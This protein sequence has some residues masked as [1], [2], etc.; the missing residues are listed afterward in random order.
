MC[1]A[2]FKIPWPGTALILVLG[3]WNFVL[4]P[5]F[6]VPKIRFENVISYILYIFIFLKPII[7]D[8]FFFKFYKFLHIYLFCSFQ[9]LFLTR[10]ATIHPLL[11]YVI[12]RFSRGHQYWIQQ[13]PKAVISSTNGKPWPHVQINQKYLTIPNHQIVKSYILGTR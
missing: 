1:L 10:S 11:S 6:W 4:N 5:T 3:S 8:D 7:L 12:P 9:C 2:F 13:T